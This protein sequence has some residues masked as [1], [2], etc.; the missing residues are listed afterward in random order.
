MEPDV[1]HDD[2][3][4]RRDSRPRLEPFSREAL[5]R[6]LN[7][8]QLDAVVYPAAP[9]LVVPGAGSGKTRVITYRLARLVARAPAPL[10]FPPLPLPN[11]APRRLRL[12][13]RDPPLH[14]PRRGL[15][16]PP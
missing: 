15:P 10:R 16:G 11:Q 13:L 8:A 7:A 1:A 14:P 12:P 6:E 5:A 9:L 4:E 2:H 3:P